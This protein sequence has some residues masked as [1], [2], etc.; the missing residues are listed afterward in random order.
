MNPLTT[1][2][3]HFNR[4]L[5]LAFFLFHT[6]NGALRK[7][8][9]AGT[10]IGNL[11]MVVQLASPLL[12]VLF[13]RRE[14]LLTQH[15]PLMLYCLVMVILAVNPLNQSIFHGI[16]GFLTHFSFLGL[17]LVYLNEREAFPFEDMMKPVIFVCL[18]Q[19][20]L[21][22][23]QFSLPS[24]HVINRYESGDEVT[25]FD[26]GLVR[27]TGSFSYIGSFGAFLYFFG[28]FVWALTVENKRNMALVYLLAVLGLVCGF[29]N[30][31]RS[32]VLPLAFFTLVG[33]ATYGGFQN[34]ARLLLIAP[35][36]V[37]L[38][39]IFNVGN[40]FPSISAAYDVFMGRVETGQ[41]TGEGEGRV[42]ETIIEVYNFHSEN[43]VWGL[44]LGAT[45]QGAVQKWGKSPELTKYGYYEEEPERI[46]LEGG[47]F[48]MVLRFLIFLYIGYQLKIPLIWSVPILSYIFFFAQL[49]SSNYQACFTFW[50]L[51]MLDKMY[52]LK[53]QQAE[54]NEESEAEPADEGG[55]LEPEFA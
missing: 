17:M 2:D 23:V 39:M 27:V 32:T 15:M 41:K 51:A 13:M 29:M 31:S 10:G 16:F 30:G 33:L 45:Y 5:L 36:L 50:G 6:L 18:A 12:L 47:Y 26:G 55:F 44:G 34:K 37:V 49:V 9:F 1:D 22:F 8:V 52:F 28:L 53:A 25:G 43:T 54:T 35:I 48:F 4:N 24:T 38:A 14:K 46:L 20:A 7:W 19:A 3:R 40:Q 11:I 21:V 42:N